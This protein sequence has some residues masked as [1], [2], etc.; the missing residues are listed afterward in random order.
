VT[1]WGDENMHITVVKIVK[2][3]NQLSGFTMEGE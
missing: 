2:G 3:L 1:D